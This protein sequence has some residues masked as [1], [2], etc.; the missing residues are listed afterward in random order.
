MIIY[1]MVVLQVH[2]WSNHGNQS[3]G[4]DC[5]GGWKPTVKPLE[6]SD[7]ATTVDFAPCS[8]GNK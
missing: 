7:A 5:G 8:H 4:Q 2:I 3:D 1:F 6:C